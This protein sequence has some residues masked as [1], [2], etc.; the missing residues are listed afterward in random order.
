M[1]SAVGS[2]FFSCVS[3]CFNLV[4]SND[5]MPWRSCCWPFS[6]A[7][8]AVKNK[9][10]KR[11]SHFVS[12]SKLTFETRPLSFFLKEK[13]KKETNEKRACLSVVRNSIASVSEI[14]NKKT[15]DSVLFF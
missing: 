4:E 9:K 1:A 5:S 3:A 8:T 6:W 15:I 11:K 13:K 12:D 7:I 2:G 10:K 14:E